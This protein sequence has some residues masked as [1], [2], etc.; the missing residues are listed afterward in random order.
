VVQ[1]NIQDYVQALF[2]GGI[3]QRSQFIIG[4]FGIL[5]ESRIGAQEIVDA[6]AVI[7]A[8]I[9]RH[10]LENGAQPD[11]ARAKSLDIAQLVLDSGKV[12]TLK[13][14]E[15]GVV[16]RLVAGRRDRV[17]EPVDHQKVNPF[18]APV[19]GRRECLGRAA[20]ILDLA[21]DGVNFGRKQ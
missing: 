17:V 2:V 18:I 8:F 10:V 14:K 20:R 4:A 16:E 7:G 12:P 1:H 5:R 6:V 13:S 3:H 9:E 15:T 11:G 21:E 19:N